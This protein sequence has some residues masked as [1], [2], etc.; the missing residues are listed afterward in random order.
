[1]TNSCCNCATSCCVR[2]AIMRAS[3]LAFACIVLASSSDLTII[4]RISAS[5]VSRSCCASPIISYFLRSS[6]ISW[7]FSSSSHNSSMATLS[8]SRPHCSFRSELS[9]MSN[10]INFCRSSKI[11][12][13]VIRAIVER[14]AEAI[15][16]TR[17]LL[18]LPFSVSEFSSWSNTFDNF[19]GS[20]MW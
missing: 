19:K 7:S 9:R 13:K 11:S 16:V 17:A 2:W 4:F 3:S 10:S 5:C 15:F 20:M 18:N 12:S 1:M 8:T 6:S 14:S